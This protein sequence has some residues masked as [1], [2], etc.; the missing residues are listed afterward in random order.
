MVATE[1]LE[2]EGRRHLGIEDPS[3][4]GGLAARLL[5]DAA[6]RH[7]LDGA[8]PLHDLADGRREP[9][10]DRPLEEP[11]RDE[12][13]Q[14]DRDRREPQI[15]DEELR[16]EL[17]AELAP[18]PLE[19]RLEDGAAEHEEHRRD[20]RDVD[21]REDEEEHAT[22]HGLRLVGAPLQNGHDGPDDE[23]GEDERDD[24]PVVLA[25]ALDLREQAHGD[26]IS[27]RFETFHSVRAS[28]GMIVKR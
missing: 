28:T 16:L 20:Q 25:P 27:K 21:V 24:E 17:G 18:P 5:A 4:G 6:F 12:E 9:P 8:R 22:G 15:R 23:D 11:G 3:R 10:V 26:L 2:I 13:E 19:V 1:G 14:P 7:V